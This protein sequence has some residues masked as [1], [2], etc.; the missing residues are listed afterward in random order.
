MISAGMCC[1][2]FLVLWL[3]ILP[4]AFVSTLH[5][6]SIPLSILIGYELL[7]YEVSHTL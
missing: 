3:L 5:W 7:G 2:A 6:Y 4:L 1:R